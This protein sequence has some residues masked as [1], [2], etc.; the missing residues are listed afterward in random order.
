LGILQKR[1]DLQLA[2]ERELSRWLN[3][4]MQFIQAVLNNKIEFKNKKKDE[5]AQQIYSNTDALNDS[6]IDRLLR[7]NILSLTDEMV[8]QLEVEIKECHSRIEYWTGT[9]PQEQFLQDINNV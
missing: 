2:E 3:V 5:V 1:I 9:S 7:I 4:K 6:D 8:K